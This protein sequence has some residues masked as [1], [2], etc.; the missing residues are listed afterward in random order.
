MKKLTALLLALILVLG[1]VPA[2]LAAGDLV[3][4]PAPVAAKSEPIRAFLIGNSFAQDSFEYLYKVF[5]AEGHSDV[6]LAFHYIGSCTLEEHIANANTNAGSYTFYYNN[7]DFWQYDSN[8]TMLRGLTE[9]DWDYIGF[10]TT[11]QRNAKPEEWGK[12]LTETIPQFM[13]YLQAKK[14][15]P[16]AKIGWQMSWSNSKDYKSDAYKVFNYDQELMYQCIADVTKNQVATQSGMDFIVPIGTAIQNARTSYI[17]DNLNRDGHHLNELGKLIASYTWY[18]TITGK[19]LDEIKFEDIKYLGVSTYP[20][21]SADRKVVAESVRNAIANPYA[22]TKSAYATKPVEYTVTSEGREHKWV[23]GDT[24]KIEAVAA[25]NRPFDKWTVVS[26]GV[27]IADPKA[28]TAT[29]TM[30][31]AN[32]ELQANYVKPD[33]S[34]PVQGDFKAGFGQR[35]IDTDKPIPLAGYG[36]T[37]QR[38]SKGRR[39]AED[40]LMANA[41]AM[42]DGKQ[43]N[44]LVVTDTIRVPS[45]WSD[46]VGERIEKELGIPADRVTIS[47][48]HT[49]SGPDIGDSESV[50]QID[51]A[52]T[53]FNDFSWYY[54]L[55]ED[56]IVGACADAVADL[57]GTSKTMYAIEEVKGM[58]YVRHWRVAVNGLGQFNGT[59]FETS[60]ASLKGHFRD[61]EQNLQVIRFFRPGEKKDIVLVNFNVHATKVGKTDLM[62]YAYDARA[63]SSADFP[64][65]LR[66]YVEQQDGD[67]HVAFFQGASGNVNSN[68]RMDSVRR[69]DQQPFYVDDYGIKMGEYVLQ[70]MK[71]MTPVETGE[72]KSMRIQHVAFNRDYV[73]GT[74]Y[75][76]QD[77]ISVG[78]IAFASAGYEMFDINGKDVKEGAPHKITFIMTSAQGH[79]YMPSWEA[80]HYYIVNNSPDAYEVKAS[81]FNEVPGTAEDLADSLIAMLNKLYKS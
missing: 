79:E 27:T 46:K 45:I 6:I 1:M 28:T 71:N 61:P 76:E 16:D 24:V 8:E 42:S 29:F 69:A 30:P 68:T 22:V 50:T 4:A 48:T 26:G 77:A 81:Q 23:P 47:A 54:Q 78:D 12:P 56:A 10:L 2:S 70:A 37:L 55:W 19:T 66:R 13:T 74:R 39:V 65:Y 34:A 7:S 58:S 9:E 21:T 15:N 64:G 31:A 5:E 80:C 52:I 63:Y 33:D 11:A 72:V 18:A 25:G 73:N 75:I 51:K 35:S 59:N 20:L 38:M 3:T 43:T 67:C 53:T 32:V 41:V 49:H 57:G 40:V 14:T 17:G 62:G 44:I 36:S 60:G